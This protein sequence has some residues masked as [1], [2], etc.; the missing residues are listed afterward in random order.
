MTVPDL[1][2]NAQKLEQSI[3]ERV[4]GSCLALLSKVGDTFAAAT[5]QPVVKIRANN[6]RTV[7]AG[8]TP[9]APVLHWGTGGFELSACIDKDDVALA[10]PLESDHAGYYA[11]GKV[12]D[13]ATTRQHDRALAVVLPFAFRKAAQAAAG[14]LFLGHKGKGLWIKIDREGL[15]M[16]LE[17]PGVNGR[18]DLGAGATL[19]A[20]RQT[21]PV[22][23]TGG[24]SAWAN[25]V[26]AA[27]ALAM[28]ENLVP[29]TAEIG[30]IS[31]GSGA[32]FIR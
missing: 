25:G 10:V 14:S 7:V 30:T 28:S 19:A 5:A 26:D 6:G 12:S 29:Y 27:L 1:L 16:E 2:K 24:F 22:T 31:G 15:R 23:A 3:L 20:A 13:P 32:T 18:L 8:P 9:D 11:S 4:R 17:I 21:D